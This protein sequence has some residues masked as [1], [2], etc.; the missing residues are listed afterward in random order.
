[1]AVVIT[2]GL[3]GLWSCAADKIAEAE[4]VMAK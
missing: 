4:K 2:S 3:Q 1:M